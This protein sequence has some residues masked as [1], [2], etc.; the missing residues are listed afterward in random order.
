MK[1]IRELLSTCIGFQWDDGN[2]RKNWIVH[3][4]DYRE[5]EQALMNRPIVFLDNV[6][7]AQNEER[8]SALGS[9]N[10]N[11]LFTIVFTIRGM[12]IRPISGRDMNIEEKRLF[13]EEGY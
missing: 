3:H 9:T 1:R 6:K 4:V 12:R 13:Y 8:F 10:A 5:I 2:L 7:H 11:R